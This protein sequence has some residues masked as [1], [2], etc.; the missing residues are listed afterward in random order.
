MRQHGGYSTSL[1]RRK[2]FLSQASP[3]IQADRE[4]V[5]E[6]VST[7]DYP[8]TALQFAS[9]ELQADRAVVLAAV[10]SNGTALQAA[11]AELQ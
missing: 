8:R 7:T 4:V 1:E 2:W 5:L 9:A 11:S 3:E 6:I 10:K